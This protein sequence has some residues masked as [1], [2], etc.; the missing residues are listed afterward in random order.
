MLPKSKMK[1]DISTIEPN[2]TGSLTGKK[3]TNAPAPEDFASNKHG[4]SADL[5]KCDVS[6]SSVEYAVQCECYKMWHCCPCGN[7]LESL[8]LTMKSQEKTNAVK[9][10]DPASEVLPFLLIKRK[11]EVRDIVIY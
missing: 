1:T 6:T 9:R 2:P 7:F 11:K 10:V 3:T 8:F 5:P 4:N